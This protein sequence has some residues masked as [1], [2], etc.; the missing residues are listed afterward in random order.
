[1]SYIITIGREYGSGGRYIARELAKRL[2]IAFYDHDL[3]TKVAKES[4]LCEEFIKENEEKKDSA[5]AYIGLSEASNF[6]SATQRVSLA[7]FKAIKKIAEKGESCIIVGRCADDILKDRPNVVSIFISAPLEDKVKRGIEYYGLDPNKATNIIK[8]ANKRRASY[9][10]YYT[11]GKW[12]RADNY[13]LCISSSIG[14][15]ETVSVIESFVKVKL[16]QYFT[17]EKEDN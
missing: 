12:G 10:N 5:F 15:E 2:G 9:Y 4:G 1:M 6:L 16:K 11:E 8:K 13:D 3:I 7:Q 17:D 14:I